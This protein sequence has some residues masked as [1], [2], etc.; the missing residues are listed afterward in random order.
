MC[1]L[2]CLLVSKASNGPTGDVRLSQEQ[3]GH[4]YTHAT[5]HDV[6]AHCR[7]HVIAGLD[8]SAGHR[9]SWTQFKREPASMCG[10]WDVSH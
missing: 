5:K 9:L 2:S 1:V 4:D 10:P 6:P 3:S 7:F 8:R